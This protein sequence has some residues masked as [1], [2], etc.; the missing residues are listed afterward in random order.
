MLTW[1]FD[2]VLMAEV[3]LFGYITFR[4]VMAALTAMGVSLLIGPLF[5]R[6]MR[7]RQ[8]GQPIREVGP[9]SHM[10]KAGTPTMGGTMV[11]VAVLVSTLL[12]ADLANRYVRSEEHTSELQSRG[13][14]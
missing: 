7:Q 3:A 6:H 1:L 10:T 5:I 9:Q 8:I 13:H 12:W 2:E 11:L 14:L 4:T